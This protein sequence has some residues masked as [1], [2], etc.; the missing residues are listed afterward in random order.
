M[1]E[2]TSGQI[3]SNKIHSSFSGD[4]QIFLNWHVLDQYNDSCKTTIEVD[5]YIMADDP[6]MSIYGT[7]LNEIDVQIS[8]AYGFHSVYY[9]NWMDIG[10]DGHDDIIKDEVVDV[11]HEPN[12]QMTF[13]IKF[14]CKSETWDNVSFQGSFQLPA[15]NVLSTISAGDFTI[16]QTIDLEVVQA[17]GNQYTHDLVA[18]IGGTDYTIAQG[19]SAGITTWN[20]STQASA[21][22]ASIPNAQFALLT[23]KCITKLNG[24]ALGTTETYVDALVDVEASLP[25]ITSPSYMDTNAT[26]V[27]IT[28]D[29]SKI[30]RNHSTLQIKASAISAINGAKLASVAVTING[31]TY[32]DTSVAGS[33][34]VSNW[35]KNIGT[36]DISNDVT[37]VMVITDT[38]GLSETVGIAITILNYEN[39]KATTSCRRVDNYYSQTNIVCNASFSSLDSHNVGTITY[40]YK[41]TTDANYNSPTT[42]VSGTTYTITLDNQYRWNIKFVLTDLLGSTTIIRTVDIG[43]PLVFFDHIRSSFGVNCFPTRNNSIESQ[44]WQVDDHI[45]VGMATLSA[46]YTTVTSSSQMICYG[47]GLDLI[48][49]MFDNI[50]IPPAYK[51]AYKITAQISTS[52]TNTGK[53]SIGGISTGTASTGG[54]GRKVV[55]SAFFDESDLTQVATPD[56]QGLILYGEKTG[57]GTAYIYNVAIACFLCKA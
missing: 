20:T 21:L 34:S 57:S 39:P 15:I 50:T 42:I 14:D 44:G 49:G 1:A 22:Y 38:R 47:V 26:T 19:V 29:S 35:A 40:Q 24:T 45:C 9:Q 33:T 41:K 18:T 11:F 55:S 7:R 36:V 12:G 2:V 28:S 51:K 17:N 13:T 16:G 4:F 37:A 32:T 43:M 23:L 27:A 53:V 56:G 46:E 5:A 31:T 6:L 30:I 52:G 54:N 10:F 25:Q 8:D 48:T 3:V